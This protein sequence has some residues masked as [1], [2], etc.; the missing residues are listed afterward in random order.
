MTICVKGKIVSKVLPI[1]T[2]RMILREITAEDAEKIVELRKKPE[3]YKYFI[4]PHVI[5]IEEHL[6]WYNKVYLQN[7]NR[8]DFMAVEKK[9][10][11][12]IGVFG[13][14]RQ[15]S[16]S[17]VGEVSYILDPSF[18]GLGYASEALGVVN[19]FIKK[20][21]NCKKSMARIHMCNK[22]SLHFIENQGYERDRFVTY[23]KDI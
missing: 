13:V 10:N 22:E 6:E 21:W 4:Y 9:S 18:Q 11:K 23:Y 12:S 8:I 14:C 5:T 20:E 19:E 3:V 7:E 2:R 17:D 15:D 16:V 1:V